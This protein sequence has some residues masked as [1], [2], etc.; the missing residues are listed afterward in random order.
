MNSSKET[1]TFSHDLIFSQAWIQPGRVL[2]SHARLLK[3]CDSMRVMRI[4]CNAFTQTLAVWGKYS[5]V[6][7]K[8]FT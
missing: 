5:A 8:I 7:V 6:D 3:N 1:L 4:M 2:Q